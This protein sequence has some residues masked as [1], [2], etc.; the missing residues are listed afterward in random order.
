LEEKMKL[1]VSRWKPQD[2]DQLLGYADLLVDELG[3]VI[4][5][6]AYREGRNGMWVSVP[7][8][9]YEADGKKKY[10]GYVSFPEREVYDDFQA[11]AKEAI[12]AH[13]AG[14]EQ[15]ASDGAEE[16]IIPF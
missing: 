12:E 8:R 2:K 13:L 14:V 10:A 7:S 16:D 9:A 4:N 6:C 1:S 11:S 15:F 5:G 3:M